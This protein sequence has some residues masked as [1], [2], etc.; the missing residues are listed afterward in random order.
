MDDDDVQDVT[1]LGDSGAPTPTSATTPSTTAKPQTASVEDEAPNKPPRPPTETQT[2]E[3][4]LKEAFPSV[5]KGVIK[6]IL[7]AS[8]GKVEPAFNALLGK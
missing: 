4:I 5:D 2:N 6:A 3:M 7:S 1:A 8:G